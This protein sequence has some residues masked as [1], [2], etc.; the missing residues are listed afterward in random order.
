M[1]EHQE[2]MQSELTGEQLTTSKVNRFSLPEMVVLKKEN[3]IRPCY[4]G[5]NFASKVHL[6][7]IGVTILKDKS[8]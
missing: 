8:T 4:L 7:H 6:R 3:N 5:Y 2:D 1:A